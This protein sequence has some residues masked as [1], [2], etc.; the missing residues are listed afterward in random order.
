MLKRL[1]PTIILLLLCTSSGHT[2]VEMKY[3]I[4]ER[5]PHDRS[6]FT[7][8]LELYG[9]RLY[10][11]TGQYGKSTVRHYAPDSPEKA[12]IRRLPGNRFGEGL[13]ILDGRVYQ[14]TWRSGEVYVYGT[15]DLSEL[16]SFSIS[17]DGWGL[18]N[19]GK[20]LIYSDGSDKL[21]YL[22]PDTGTVSRVVNVTMGGK[23]VEFLNELEW[24]RG[25]I[26]A[27]VLPTNLIVVIDPQDGKVK[28][29]LDLS[30]LYPDRMRRSRENIANGLAW[31]HRRHQL[32]VTGKNWPWLYRLRLIEPRIQDL[33]SK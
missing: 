7:Q 12:V 11:S 6:S 32:L 13:T 8:G 31:D 28:R 9:D 16:S 10:E 25:S 3:E 15:T 5:L 33:I 19:N 4:L 21:R 17:G 14:L 22:D 1:S 24:V 18:T 30:N 20:Q 27:N 2:A 26:Y 23:P 29:T